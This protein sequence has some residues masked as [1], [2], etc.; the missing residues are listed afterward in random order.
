MSL[1]VSQNTASAASTLVQHLQK[2][3]QAQTGQSSAA[4]QT[5]GQAAKAHHHHH[6]L[7]GSQA[8][9]ASSSGSRLDTLA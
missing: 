4:L 5:D 1:S 7:S 9:A 3:A 8:G 6:A 2:Q